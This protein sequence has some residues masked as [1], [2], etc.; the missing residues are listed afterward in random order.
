M[1]LNDITRRRLS[2]SRQAIAWALVVCGFAASCTM[3]VTAKTLAKYNAGTGAAVFDPVFQWG[4]A[5]RNIAPIPGAPHQGVPI[6]NDVGTGLNAWTLDDNL[7]STANP[8]Y[9]ECID[10]PVPGASCGIGANRAAALQNG[11]RFS[12]RA[13]YLTDYGTDGIGNMGLSVWIDN[14]GYFV[15]FDLSAGNLRATTYSG[16][17]ASTQTLLTS[18]GVGTAA[19]HEFALVYRPATQQTVFEFDGVARG[20]TVGQVSVHENAMLWGNVSTSGR[21]SMNFHDVE[22]R[23][24]QPGDYNLNERVDAADYTVWRDRIGS[25]NATA[26]GNGSGIVDIA[27]YTLW[28]QNFGLPAPTGSGALMAVPELSGL[29]LANWAATGLLLGNLRPK[30][31][32][33]SQ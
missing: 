33:L 10:L 22:F 4:W 6:V 1:G 8:F 28:Q 5:P 2:C 16:A 24:L 26:D 32:P 9:S 21:G 15:L 18:G 30:R 11:W 20:V 14:R 31:A 27:D 12:A 25:P 17:N 13:R 19:Y 3:P 23:I 29:A 7:T